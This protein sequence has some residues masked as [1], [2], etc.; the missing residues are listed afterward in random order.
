[1]VVDYLLA[2]C[3]WDYS[4]AVQ[5]RDLIVVDGKDSKHRGIRKRW[6]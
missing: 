1:M 3:G 4:V 6:C 2:A 5:C